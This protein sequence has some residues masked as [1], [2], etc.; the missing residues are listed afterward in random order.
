MLAYQHTVEDLFGLFWLPVVEVPV[1]YS[2]PLR[3]DGEIV[4]TFG[5]ENTLWSTKTFV[6]DK[7][8]AVEGVLDDLPDGEV[9]MAAVAVEFWIPGMEL[10]AF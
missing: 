6:H 2:I 5:V 1:T 10:D 8:I 3:C 7:T 4:G 9:S